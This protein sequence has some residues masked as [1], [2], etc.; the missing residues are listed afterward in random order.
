MKRNKTILG[1]L[2]DIRCRFDA[3]IDSCNGTV[4]TL[5]GFTVVEGTIDCCEG[6]GDSVFYTLYHNGEGEFPVYGDTIYIDAQGTETLYNNSPADEGITL[7]VE[8]LW[9]TVDEEGI[10]FE[11]VCDCR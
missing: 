9:L 5:T 7:W 1:R 10:F 4:S 8:G 2:K 3:I 11:S 6:A